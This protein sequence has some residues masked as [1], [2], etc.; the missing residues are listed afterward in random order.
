MQDQE[1]TRTGQWKDWTMQGPENT[2]IG[3]AKL[4]KVKDWK[5]QGMDYA[6]TEQCKNW[7]IRG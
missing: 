6:K 7:S 1:S 3:N 4:R 2:S 5:T